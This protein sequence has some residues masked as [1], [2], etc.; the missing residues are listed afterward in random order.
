MPYPIQLGPLTDRLRKFFRIRGKSAFML[1]EVVV[2]V[3]LVQD[4]TK[5]PYQAGVTPCAAG[6]LMPAG[7]I[8]LNP[9][10]AVLLQDKPSTLTPV[11]PGSFDNDT[12]SMTWVEI[13]SEAVNLTDQE[14][15]MGLIN[16]SAL[17]A[18]VATQAQRLLSIERNDGT[19]TVPVEMQFYDDPVVLLTSQ[20]LWRG[21]LAAPSGPNVNIATLL[22]YEPEP[23]IT[24]GPDDVI[25]FQTVPGGT[26][27]INISIR[28]FYQQQPA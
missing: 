8:A 2:P 13:S 27:R 10:T 1:D 18:F 23:Q 17:T 21:T 28:G 19:Q 12:Y 6:F 4:L 3:A 24:I 26:N 16:R 22:V 11:L 9:S 20:T 7:N 14:V 25:V 5:G 15:R